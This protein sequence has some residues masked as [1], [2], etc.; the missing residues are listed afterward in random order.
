MANRHEERY[1]ASFVTMEVQIKTTRRSP[2][3]PTR[4]LKLKRLNMPGVGE[5]M[6]QLKF[7]DIAEGN[8]K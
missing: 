3:T 2:Y 7:P 5:D 4:W 8:G 6:E 1:S